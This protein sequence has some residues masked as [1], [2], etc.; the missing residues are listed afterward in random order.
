MIWTSAKIA[1]LRE[2][3]PSGLGAA[4]IASRVGK[5]EDA[6]SKKAYRLGIAIARNPATCFAREDA[7]EI[8][9]RWAKLIGPLKDQ[10]RATIGGI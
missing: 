4:L 1:E 7:G 8:R 6:V 5:S 9:A 2:L 10:L 3:A